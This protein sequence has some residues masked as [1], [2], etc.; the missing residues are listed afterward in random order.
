M[1]ARSQLESGVDINDVDEFM[2]NELLDAEA[3]QF[4]AIAGAADA[5]ERQVD[6][7]HRWIVDEDDAS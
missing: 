1:F 3:E 2:V 6:P 5:A 4:P 7:D